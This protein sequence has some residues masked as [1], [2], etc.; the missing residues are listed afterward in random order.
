MESVVAEKGQVTIP[1]RLRDSLGLVPGAHLEFEERKGV[2]VVRKMV[3]D[4]GIG[5][6]VGLLEPMDVDAEI[7]AARGP[8]LVT[9]RRARSDAHRRR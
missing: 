7:V 6:L 2:L 5:R 3:P 1:K 4:D 8:A 9:E